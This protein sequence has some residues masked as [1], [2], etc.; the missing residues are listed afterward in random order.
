MG[1]GAAQLV[2]LLWALMDE[3]WGYLF[4]LTTGQIGWEQSSGQWYLLSMNL[5]EVS[6]KG[7]DIIGSVMSSVHNQVVALA[8][9]STLLPVEALT[10]P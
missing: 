9:L 4:D 1:E 8:Q 5:P 2:D 7:K 6:E 10:P 3:V